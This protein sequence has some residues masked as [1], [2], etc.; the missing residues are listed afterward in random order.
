MFGSISDKGIS[1]DLTRNEIAALAR[2]T[3][4][5]VSRE[6]SELR[7]A[8]ILRTNSKTLLI[9]DPKKLKKMIA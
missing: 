3:P 4:T 9:V 2:T 5:Q 7:K 1:L 8:Q 6:I